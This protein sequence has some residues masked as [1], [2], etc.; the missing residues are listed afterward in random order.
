[1]RGVPAAAG[2]GQEDSLHRPFERAHAARQM[3]YAARQTANLPRVPERPAG[4]ESPPRAAITSNA[5]SM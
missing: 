4:G 5:F 1:M 3:V 2:Q